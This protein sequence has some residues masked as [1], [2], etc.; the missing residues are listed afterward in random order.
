LF[1]FFKQKTAYEIQQGDWS[2]DVCSSD[3]PQ[4]APSPA[5]SGIAFAEVWQFAQSPQRKDVAARCTNYSRDGDCNA[6]GVA[7]L[8]I[9]ANSATSAD[10]S[11]GRIR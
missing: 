2:S 4:S 11:H 9:D 3:L 1:F 8:A 7:T 10:P 5:Q 6:P